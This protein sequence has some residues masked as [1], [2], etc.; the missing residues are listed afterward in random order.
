MSKA[1]HTTDDDATPKRK[2]RGASVMAWV[3]MAMIVGGLGG[4]GVTNF[5]GNVTTIGAV[6]DRDITVNDYVQGMRQQVNQLSQQFG[7]QLTME[8]ARAFGID[9]QVL[10]SLVQRAALDNEA[11]HVGLSAGDAV[12]AAELA[13]MPSF[14]GVSGTFDGKTY[15]DALKNNNLT[16][17][18]FEDGIRADIARSLLQGSVAGG[19]VAPQALTDTI[20][21][22]AGERRGFTLVR[23][24]EADLPAPLPAP[25]EAE[26]QAW[27][28]A[29][30]ADYTRPEAKRITYAALLPADVAKTITIDEAEVKAAY[31]AR[32]SEF[33]LPEKRLVERLV[34]GTEA[35]A[36]AAKARLDAGESFEALVAERKLTLEDIDMGDV[37]KADLGAAG[38]AVFALTEPGTVGPLPSSLGPA[39]Y[40]MNAVLA[41][42]ETTFE[43]A[44]PKLLEELQLAAAQKAISDKVEAIDDLLAGGAALDELARDEGMVLATTDYAPGAED[45]APIT[46]QPA[47][48]KA[49]AA[50]AEG[51]FPEAIVLDDGGLVAMQLDEVV[52][53]TPRP[54]DAVKDAVTAALRA[55]ALA[56]ALSAR[57]LEMKTAV[58]GGAALGAQGIAERTA[59]AD[60]QASVEGAPA[61]L[62]TA[63]FAMQPGELRLI[64]EAGFTALVRLDDI[65]PATA[66]GADAQALREAIAVNAARAL[67]TDLF[68]LY[69]GALTAEAGITLNQ[70]AIDAV[71]AQLGN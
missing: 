17:T 60:R 20:F 65:Q 6:G 5:G 68:A 36:A 27:Y 10:Q 30:L 42:Q 29:H 66:E 62:I 21:A 43:Q 67:S 47:F 26:V 44:K 34:F 69:T 9:G 58:E 24:T 32:L 41:A 28:D 12:V 71:N 23:V 2:R 56:K 63:V 54:L 1:P 25:T 52:P 70:A 22:W 53:P 19:V 64:E 50:L 31:D 14:Q 38:D 33:M 61:S 57:G 35:E 3:L 7:A 15:R 51:D 55:D 39:L 11:A 37:S 8:Q 4:F 13:G 46:A 45:N 18:E 40:R 49:A 59:S 48:A 16:A